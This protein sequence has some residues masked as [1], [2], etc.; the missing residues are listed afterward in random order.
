MSIVIDENI[1]GIWYALTG[2][3]DDFML[4]ISKCPEGLEMVYRIRYY[5]SPDDPWDENDRKSWYRMVTPQKDEEKAVEVAREMVA[6]VIAIAMK[7]KKIPGDGL[8]YELLRGDASVEEFANRLQ[9][10][11]WAHAKEVRTH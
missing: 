11:P 10:M 5:A 2:E 9:S 4:A 8:M 7:M 3:A 1:I 6:G